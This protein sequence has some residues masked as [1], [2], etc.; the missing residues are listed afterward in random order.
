MSMKRFNRSRGFTLLEVLVALA[1]VAV[2]LAALV[3]TGAQATDN[4]AYL[5]RKTFA[6]WVAMNQLVE[7][8]ATGAGLSKGRSEGTEEMAGIEWQWQRTVKPTPDA[9]LMQVEFTVGRDDEPQLVIL[10][11][12]VPSA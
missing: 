10:S 9:K 8:Q 7:L 6:H 12:F 5:E 2:A 3:R 11:G 1:I 4:T